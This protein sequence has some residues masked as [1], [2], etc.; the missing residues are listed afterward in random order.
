[1]QFTFGYLELW[2]DPMVVKEVGVVEAASGALQLQQVAHRK[3]LCHLVLVPVKGLLLLL[4]RQQAN[5]TI[6]NISSSAGAE[7]FHFNSIRLIER[8]RAP[9]HPQNI[10]EN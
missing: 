6:I 8:E 2:S 3:V 9:A 5:I 1:M 4:G 7:I 10:I